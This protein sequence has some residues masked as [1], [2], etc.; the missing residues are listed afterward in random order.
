MREAV[1]ITV[2]DRS[3]RAP[4][5]YALG[6]GEG[7]FSAVACLHPSFFGT[8]EQLGEHLAVPICIIPAKDDPMEITQGICAG[9]PF[10]AK[11]KFQR[12]DHMMHGFMAARGD[13]N[14]AAVVK[15]VGEAN[16]IL[17]AFFEENLP[18]A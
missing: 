4:Q 5:V 17:A 2:A 3:T 8:E 14:D 10:A 15:A 6:N 11:C 13:F 7:G 12:F 18:Q 1:S 9:K 16:G